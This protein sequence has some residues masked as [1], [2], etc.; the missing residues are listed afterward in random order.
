MGGLA[1]CLLVL[2]S[3]VAALTETTS[4]DQLESLEAGLVAG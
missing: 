4:W 1:S 2:E 3:S